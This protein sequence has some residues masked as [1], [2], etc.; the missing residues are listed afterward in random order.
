MKKSRKALKPSFSFIPGGYLLL[1]HAP[2]GRKWSERLMKKMQRGNLLRVDDVKLFAASLDPNRCDVNQVTKAFVY[3]LLSSYRLY[4]AF[5][6]RY[7]AAFAVKNC[8]DDLIKY[9]DNTLGHV[10]GL[11]RRVAREEKKNNPETPSRRCLVFH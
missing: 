9:W 8:C 10:E 6:Q 3:R 1:T 5:F 11:P 4:R 2:Q 7:N